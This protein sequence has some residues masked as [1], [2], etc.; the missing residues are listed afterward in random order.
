[1]RTNL[2]GK[3]AAV[4]VGL[5]GLALAGLTVREAVAIAG[6]DTDSVAS[7]LA[8]LVL[9]LV[10]AAAVIAFAVAIWRG[11]SWGRSGGIVT[12]LLILAVALGAATGAF[13]DPAVALALAAPA[14]L[15]LV[16]LVLAVRD[17]GRAAHEA[18]GRG[19]DGQGSAS[20]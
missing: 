14:I 13:A 16:L 1:M 8:L 9:T 7:A 2:S 3:I 18:D 20:R 6:G 10:G 11:Q 17:A 19:S 12:Q 15:T 5:E 4:L